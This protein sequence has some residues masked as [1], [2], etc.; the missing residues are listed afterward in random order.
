MRTVATHHAILITRKH[1]NK[2]ARQCAVN[3]YGTKLEQE[4]YD[5]VRTVANHNT[6][7]TTRR[8]QKKHNNVQSRNMVNT[9]YR[10]HDNPKKAQQRKVLKH[11]ESP[12]TDLGQH[13]LCCQSQRYIDTTKNMNKTTMFSLETGQKETKHDIK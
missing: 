6:I 5:M 11:G 4:T 10:H 2:H 13:P 1:K 12:T 8:K 3:K 7:S 9:L